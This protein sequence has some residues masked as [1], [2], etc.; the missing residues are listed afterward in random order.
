MRPRVKVT[1]LSGVDRNATR[2]NAF[3]TCL[4]GS[5]LDDIEKRLERWDP[6]W[7][8]LVDCSVTSRTIRGETYEFGTKTAPVQQC[9]PLVKA[10]LLTA[11]QLNVDFKK[12]ERANLKGFAWGAPL[13][14]SSYRNGDKRFIMRTLPLKIPE[15]YKKKRSDTHNWPKGEIGKEKLGFGF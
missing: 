15:K 8:V 9:V 13:E 3:G 1:F 2:H 12:V 14:S 6:Y 10:P 7:K 5:G 11:C 4:E